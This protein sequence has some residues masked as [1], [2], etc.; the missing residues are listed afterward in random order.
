MRFKVIDKRPVLVGSTI[1]KKKTGLVLKA[2]ILK[3]KKEKRQ[4]GILIYENHI[5]N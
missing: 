5:Y 2:R 4:K 3:A 1:H